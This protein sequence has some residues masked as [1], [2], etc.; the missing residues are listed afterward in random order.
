MK[1]YYTVHMY[2]LPK[3]NKNST[4]TYDKYVK[5]NDEALAI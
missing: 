1:N 4:Y 5:Q 2:V 3:I